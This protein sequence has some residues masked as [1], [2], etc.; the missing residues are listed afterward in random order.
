M[1]GAFDE[2]LYETLPVPVKKGT[3][4]NYY[5]KDAN[6]GDYEPDWHNFKNI[7]EAE[8]TSIENVMTSTSIAEEWYSIGGLRLPHPQP[9]LNILKVNGKTFKVIKRQ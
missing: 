1:V 7:T 5:Y 4:D 6:T 3:L 8:F 2:S 9:G